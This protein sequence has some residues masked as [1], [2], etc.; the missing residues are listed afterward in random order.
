M[1]TTT[2]SKEELGQ[3]L[4][5][6]A[7]YPRRFAK[8]FL[9]QRGGDGT[10]AELDA[11]LAVA[12]EDPQARAVADQLE[13]NPPVRTGYIDISDEGRIAE[14]LAHLAILIR[15][16]KLTQ[17]EVADRC[18]FSQPQVAAYLSGKKEPGIRNLAKLA[19]AVGCVWRL[20]PTDQA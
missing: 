19:A 8:E 11:M 1:T 20:L 2:L 18:G 6:V 3:L 13:R 10:P 12:A 16:Q 14:M 5:K 17:Q 9:R 15:E 7:H 4:F